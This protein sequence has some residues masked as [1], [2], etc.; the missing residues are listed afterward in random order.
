MSKKVPQILVYNGGIAPTGKLFSDL[1]DMVKY[2]KD[3][4][5]QKAP[6]VLVL[7]DILNNTPLL[8]NANDRAR[9][10]IAEEHFRTHYLHDKPADVTLVDFLKDKLSDKD[11]KDYHFDRYQQLIE[12]QVSSSRAWYAAAAKLLNKLP[13]KTDVLIAPGR[14]DVRTII[15]PKLDDESHTLNALVLSCSDDGFTETREG[16][17][18]AGI[19]AIG[20]PDLSVA[21][22]LA[23]QPSKEFAT[24]IAFLNK[25]KDADVLLTGELVFEHYDDS[26]PSNTIEKTN[27]FALMLHDFYRGAWA[28]DG[29]A[30]KRTK[31][32]VTPAATTAKERV[33]GDPALHS[34]LVLNVGPVMNAD[35]TSERFQPV[36]VIPYNGNGVE[37]VRAVNIN[38]GAIGAGATPQVTVFAT[39]EDLF[40]RGS[41][42]PGKTPT[43]PGTRVITPDAVQSVDAAKL[44]GEPAPADGNI[45]IRQVRVVDQVEIRVHAGLPPSTTHGTNA[46]KP[47]RAPKRAR[48]ADA[49]KP[50]S[51][52]PVAPAPAA[53]KAKKPRAP[54]AARVAP[55]SPTFGDSLLETTLKNNWTAYEGRWKKMSEERQYAIL[56]IT[57]A[58]LTGEKNTERAEE[59]L[60]AISGNAH[61]MR[62]QVRSYTKEALDV[63][64]AVLGRSGFKK[65][66]ADL[67]TKLEK[68]AKKLDGND[69]YVTGL[70]GVIRGQKQEIRALVKGHRIESKQNRDEINAFIKAYCAA[71]DL[72][73]IANETFDSDPDKSLGEYTKAYE[74]LEQH[75]EQC[76]TFGKIVKQ[77]MKTI[78]KP[79]AGILYNQGRDGDKDAYKE[80]LPWYRKTWRTDE[81]KKYMADIKEELATESAPTIDQ[82]PL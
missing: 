79:I 64:V 45:V 76:S 32:V 5:E 41:T 80:A 44:P 31:L 26:I 75:I 13:A 66:H 56:A 1:E 14:H 23:S 58:F 37:K 57:E 19:G 47:A 30:R 10:A 48:A 36:Y 11:K 3:L 22:D 21:Y 16:I 70:Q 42:D 50:A 61:Y 33:W 25:H 60:S 52:A 7:Y 65:K 55:E 54:R 67:Y 63:L 59:V 28:E 78:A 72:Y 6:A 8:S 43:K 17:K 74:T 20:S 2:V 29:F 71:A 40:E 82:L 49:S 15:D 69:V 46:S 24:E 4:D 27:G 12:E 39:P 34:S 38:P 18:F 9:F 62:G 77:A 53:P 73:R 68:T 81:N 35:K 51:T